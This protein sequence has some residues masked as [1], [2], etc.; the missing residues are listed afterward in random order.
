LTAIIVAAADVKASVW[1]LT[2]KGWILAA[3][4]KIQN[5]AVDI[6]LN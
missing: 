6:Y 4:K 1:K 5:L 2:M 3:K